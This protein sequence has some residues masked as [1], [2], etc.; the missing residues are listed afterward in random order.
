MSQESKILIDRFPFLS[1]FEIAGT[2]YVGIIQNQGK[3]VVS[4]YVYNNIRNSALKKLFLELGEAWWWESN[5]KIPINLF[6]KD[7]FSP[8]KP[9]LVSCVAKEFTLK[10]G[11]TISIHNLNQKRVKRRRI[12]LIREIP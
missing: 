10:K 12:D 2:E 3:S 4:A 1:L 6:L 7:E 9:F 11:P 8:F 5:R